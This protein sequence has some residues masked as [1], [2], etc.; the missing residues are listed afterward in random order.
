MDGHLGIL[1]LVNSQEHRGF[2]LLVSIVDPLYHFATVQFGQEALWGY[3]SGYLLIL[4]YPKVRQKK[5][6]S[7]PMTTGILGTWIV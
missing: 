3:L 6:K 4:L 7:Q 1:I 5:K 2:I